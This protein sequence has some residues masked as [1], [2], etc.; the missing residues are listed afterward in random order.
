MRNLEEE[1]HGDRQVMQDGHGLGLEGKGSYCIYC[2]V[3]NVTTIVLYAMCTTIY[4]VV[5]FIV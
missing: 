5:L 3:Y 2:F 4:C 1:F